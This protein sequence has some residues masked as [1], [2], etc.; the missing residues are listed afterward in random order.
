MII[1]DYNGGFFGLIFGLPLAALGV[2]LL[3]MGAGMAASG[4]PTEKRKKE[5]KIFAWAGASLIGVAIVIAILGKCY[6]P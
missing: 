6:G 1:A 2:I 4:N 3:L 5:A